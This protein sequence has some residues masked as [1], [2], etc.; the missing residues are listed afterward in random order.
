MRLMEGL[1]LR[2]KDVDFDR[3]AILVREAKG[4]EDRVIMLPQS[5]APALRLQVRHARAVWELDRQA[6]RCGVQTPHALDQKYPNVGHSW[7]WFW[8][9]P[10]PALSVDPASGVERRHHL[11]EERLQRAIKKAVADAGIAKPVSV[12]T[13]F[14]CHASAAKR[15]GHP[16]RA[17]TAGPFGCQHHHDLHPCAEGGDNK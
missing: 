4:N 17:G 14:V 1:R 6:G 9:F 10:S 15:H 8:V 2:V 16:H 7:G 3:R 11:F 12:H 5:L 13:S